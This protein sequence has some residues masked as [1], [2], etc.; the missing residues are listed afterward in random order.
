[1]G[2][3]RVNGAAE[4]PGEPVTVDITASAVYGIP[5]RPLIERLR[6]DVGRAVRRHTELNV[7]AVNITVQDLHTPTPGEEDA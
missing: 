2:S 5:V 4:T 3:C 1:M 6:D 7:I